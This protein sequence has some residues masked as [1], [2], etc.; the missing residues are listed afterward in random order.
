MQDNNWNLLEEL[1]EILYKAFNN[2]DATEHYATLLKL[3]IEKIEKSI[4]DEIKCEKLKILFLPYKL[5]MWTAMESIWEAAMKD[6][7]CHV[8]VVP[9]PYYNIADKDNITMSYEGMEYPK[10]INIIDYRGYDVEKEHP[11][12]I[13]IHN[14]Y[15]NANKITSIPE[16]Y[17]SKNIK[18]HTECLVYSPYFTF[19][20]YD[21]TKSS[22]LF[23]Q[24]GTLYSDKI[25]V[26]SE[27]VKEL[28][29]SL[30]FSDKR[31]MVTGSPKADAVRKYTKENVDMPEEWKEK[32]EGKKVFLLNTH[33][34]Y[35]PR[36]FENALKTGNNYA[37]RF[38]DEILE[39]IKDRDDVGL[40][41]RPHPLLKNK[42]YDSAKECIEYIEYFEKQLIESNNCVIDTYGEYKYS[43]AYSDAMISTWSSLIN[44]YMITEKPVMI[45]Q[46]KISEE[47]IKEAVINRNLNY[48]RFG[49]GGITFLEFIENVKCGIDEKKEERMNN[50]KQA[51]TNFGGNAGQEAYVQ[52]KNI[53]I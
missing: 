53:L 33:L 48:F 22:F 38:H 8:S 51:F 9:I 40:I 5:S 26:Q 31:L 7:E 43:F 13:I 47:V 36:S 23:I 44:E 24:P 14:P 11:E 17:Y 35:F 42:V 50:L 27:R 20:T 19:S 49:D 45:F 3:H 21:V 10:E 37:V 52:L 16:E 34:N 25:I 1:C 29:M 12:I 30:G 15:D 39:A 6:D 4:T 2:L 41:W 18:K 28:F 46:G 32:L